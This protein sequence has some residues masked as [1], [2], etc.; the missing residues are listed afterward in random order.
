MTW[1]KKQIALVVIYGALAYEGIICLL[2]ILASAQTHHSY[3]I[4]LE[5]GTWMM[6]FIPEG[7]LVLAGLGWVGY[8][9][10]KL[11]GPRVDKA[12]RRY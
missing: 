11:A 10:W 1:T 2:A 12:D 3:T 4:E 9:V 5:T 8:K 6:W 7:C